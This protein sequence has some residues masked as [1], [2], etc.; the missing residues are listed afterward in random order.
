MN[1]MAP[2]EPPHLDLCCLQV[3]IVLLLLH[4]GLK[5][6]METKKDK[7]NLSSVSDADQEIPTKGKTDNAGNAVYPVSGIFR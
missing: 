6:G 5:R 7:K 3:Q 2:Y 1:H 4:K